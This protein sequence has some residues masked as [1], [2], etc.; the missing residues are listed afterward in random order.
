VQSHVEK[1]LDNFFLLKC[2]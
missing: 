1:V 2:N